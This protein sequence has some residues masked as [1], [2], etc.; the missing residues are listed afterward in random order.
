MVKISTPPNESPT[1]IWNQNQER[2]VYE[3]ILSQRLHFVIIFFVIVLASSFLT[4]DKSKDYLITILSIGTIIIWA[5][6]FTVL[7]LS[8]K[9][10][11]ITNNSGSVI[12]KPIK[13]ILKIPRI[14][15]GWLGDLFI[16]VFC[17]LIITVGLIFASTGYFDS[18]ILPHNVEE[19]IKDVLPSLKKTVADSSKKKTEYIKEFQNIDSLLKK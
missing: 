18:Q 4:I 3:T 9:L 5:L 17:S 19:K 2:I 10:R 15:L 16:P 14:I 7:R 13:W 8:L 11:A 6:T 12:T 1:Q